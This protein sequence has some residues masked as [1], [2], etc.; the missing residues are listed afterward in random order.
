MRRNVRREPGEASEAVARKIWLLLELFRHRVVR[1]SD[2]QRLYQRDRRSFQ[3]DLQ[4]LRAIGKEAGF[5][6]SRIADRS[7]AHLTSVSEGLMALGGAT[8]S[9]VRTISELVR[10]FGAPFQV[11]VDGLTQN[12]DPKDSFLRV[13]TPLLANGSHVAKVYEA[14]RAAWSSPSGPSR[15]RF[16]FDCPGRAREERTVDP[17]HVI[18]RW[19]RYYLFAYDPS[20]RNWRYFPLD[21]IVSIPVKAGSIQRL[22]P[23]PPVHASRDVI[24]FLKRTHAPQYVTVE[25]YG[26]AAIKVASRVWN[27]QQ[28]LEHLPDGTVRVTMPVDDPYEIILWSFWFG[29]QSRVVAPPSAVQ[30]TTKLLAEMSALYVMGPKATDGQRDGAVSPALDGV[31]DSAKLRSKQRRT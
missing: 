21:A 29:E 16:L 1:F 13:L 15:V 31:R 18:M 11:E 22:R 6:I 4:Q 19:G 27:S 10:A 9:V 3:R 30:K 5:S 14:L 24:G 28:T 25:F 12:A 17:Y 20:R 26:G 23:I 2:Y 8:S 7:N